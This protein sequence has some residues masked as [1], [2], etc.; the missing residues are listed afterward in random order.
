LEKKKFFGQ[1]RIRIGQLF[2]AIVSRH[3]PLEPRSK[4]DRWSDDGSE[5]NEDQRLNGFGATQIMAEL[6]SNSNLT[7]VQS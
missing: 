3:S 7:Q 5:L 2:A 1:D 4:F 6:K